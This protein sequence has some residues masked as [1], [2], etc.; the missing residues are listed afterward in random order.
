MVVTVAALT[1]YA[2]GSEATYSER[3][4]E[5][6]KIKVGTIGYLDGEIGMIVRKNDDGSFI[7]RFMEP[8]VAGRH[9]RHYEVTALMV[10]LIE[11]ALEAKKRESNPDAGR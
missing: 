8:G 4:K 1:C 11:G 9:I 10:E 3:L 5:A 2:F 7:V 6:Q